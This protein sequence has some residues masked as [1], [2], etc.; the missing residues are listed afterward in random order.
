[1]KS[2]IFA[3]F[4]LFFI[5]SFTVEA[6]RVKGNGEIVT[7]EIEVNDYESITI[8]GG[9]DMGESNNN[10]FVRSKTKEMVP[11]FNYKQASGKASLR[12][13]TDE[14]L[15]AH[16]SIENTNGRLIIKSKD[17]DRLIPTKMVI[18]GTSNELT[19]LTVTGSMD[20]N[21]N[22]SL[23]GDMLTV[24]CSGSSDVYMNRPVD[25]REVSIKVSGS[26]DFY[27]DN[28]NCT[29]I[30][31]SVSGSADARLK[32]KAEEG[33]YTV[34]GSGDIHAY[35]FTVKNLE[36]KV[37]GSGDI[38]AYATDN[39]KA[40]ASGS[41]DIRYKGNPHCNFVSTGSGDIKRAN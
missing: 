14:N 11:T 17:K 21:L 13:T 38:K 37:S 26:G 5:C 4:L 2:K 36:S 19:S 22:S 10:F 28:L 8:G 25:M 9:I 20:F 30:I 39:L 29:S 12:I 16:L 32:G 18:D 1:M 34:S 41:G 6:K 24:V 40:R 23:S 33:K 15:I 31:A 35:D 3:L 7:R 27:S